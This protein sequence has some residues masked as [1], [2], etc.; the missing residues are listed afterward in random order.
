[1]YIYAGGGAEGP[2]SDMHAFCFAD[3]RWQPV[4]YGNPECAPPPRRYHS[5]CLHG[6]RLYV[7]GGWDGISYLNDFYAFDLETLL[8]TR[9]AGSAVTPSVRCYHTCVA[10]GDALY[11]FGGTS[12]RHLNDVWQFSVRCAAL[13]HVCGP[14]RHCLLCAGSVA[15][16]ASG[17]S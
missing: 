8:W 13:V 17:P 7:F 4:V 14:P 1:M 2:L 6:C 11:V 5:M 10:F 12:A 15:V 16:A 3:R 9:I